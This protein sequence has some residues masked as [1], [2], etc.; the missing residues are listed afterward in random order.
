MEVMTVWTPRASLEKTRNLIG[1]VQNH[2]P[3]AGQRES[4]MDFKAMSFESGRRLLVL[5]RH[6]EKI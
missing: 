4:E 5:S 1:T 2:T 3:I 6:L